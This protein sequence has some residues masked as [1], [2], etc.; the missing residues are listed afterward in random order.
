MSACF[1]TYCL[2]RSVASNVMKAMS[3]ARITLA[4]P[5]TIMTKSI[6][7]PD[8]SIMRRTSGRNVNTNN[9]NEITTAILNPESTMMCE[10]HAVRNVCVVSFDNDESPKSIP[11]ASA[12]SGALT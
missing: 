7:E 3:V 5:P 8:A 2:P 10:S 9:T 4:S 1:A 12:F 6:T 11:L